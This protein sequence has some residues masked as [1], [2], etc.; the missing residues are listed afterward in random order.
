MEKDPLLDADR[1]D[2]A[3]TDEVAEVKAP[4]SFSVRETSRLFRLTSS[5]FVAVI[6]ADSEEEAREL[7]TR[8]DVFGG[9]WRDAAFSSA[10]FEDTSEVHVFGDV[11]FSA[12]GPPPRGARK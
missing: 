4:A 12:G 9:N 2:V 8:Q 10:E 1:T 7:A 5:R 11:T 6:A 3:A